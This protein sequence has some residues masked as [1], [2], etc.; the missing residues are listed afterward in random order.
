MTEQ[1]NI[2]FNSADF[3]ITS[4]ALEANDAIV[5]SVATDG[6]AITPS[7][8]EFTVAGTG[9]ITTSG[10]GSTV[11]VDGSGITSDWVLIT[12]TT[13]SA[14]ASIDFTDLSSSYAV[15]KLILTDIIPA[16]NNAY[17]GIRTSTDNGS[18]YDT[19][20]YSYCS[21]RLY[22][23]SSPNVHESEA[24]DQIDLTSECH[25]G[26]VLNGEIT[27]YNP[28]GTSFT[29][30]VGRFSGRDD[31]NGGEPVLYMGVGIRKSAADV[32]AIQCRFDAGNITSGTIKLYGVVPS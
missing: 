17:F 31:A 1:N 6:D 11:T 8:H 29:H 24:G 26:N 23:S 12:S 30:A 25:G 28:A 2:N 7:T 5:K 19:S 9:G 3:T 20:G 22:V 21:L 13:A 10:A 27:L 16:T 4:G 32:D 18:A 15:Y 14:D